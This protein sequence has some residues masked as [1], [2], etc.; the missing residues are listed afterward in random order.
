MTEEMGELSKPWVTEGTDARAAIVKTPM[1]VP[2]SPN[3]QA[4]HAGIVA[5]AAQSNDPELRQLSAQSQQL[6][7]Q[8]D[9]LVRGMYEA[10]TTLSK[11]SKSGGPMLLLRDQLFPEGLR[12]NKKSHLAEAGHAA[13]V[14]ASMT[15]EVRARM[16]AIPLGDGTVCDL[17][18]QWQGVSGQLGAV[19]G[20]IARLKQPSKSLA[21]QI[22]SARREWIRWARIL[23]STA[24]NAGVSAETEAVLFAPLREA[25]QRADARWRNGPAPTPPAPSEDPTKK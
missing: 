7:V 5:V 9:D 3:L 4:A 8:H 22:Q 18:D 17:Y 11:M 25:Q 21:A 1:L 15:D 6:D 10:L 19:Q 23:M 14:A 2:L 20:Q 24:E 16:K 12:H 13:A